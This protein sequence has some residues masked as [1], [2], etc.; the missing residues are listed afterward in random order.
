[1]L[2]AI[3][4]ESYSNMVEALVNVLKEKGLSDSRIGL[5]ERV[6]H[7][8]YMNKLKEI[9]KQVLLPLVKFFMK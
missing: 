5:D 4:I 9:K 8:I 2:N 3:Y 1:M 6:Y 7:L